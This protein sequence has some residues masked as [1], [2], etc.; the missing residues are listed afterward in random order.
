[1]WVQRDGG[2]DVGAER[3]EYSVRAEA[4]VE[5]YIH[6]LLH[7]HSRTVD[8]NINNAG[9]EQTTSLAGPTLKNMLFRLAP[10]HL[11]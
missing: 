9:F 7:G 1:M 8:G 3:Q 5:M 2:A 6:I 4:L 10:A 11:I